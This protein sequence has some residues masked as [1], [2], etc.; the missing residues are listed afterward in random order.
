MYPYLVWIHPQVHFELGYHPRSLLPLVYKTQDLGSQGTNFFVKLRV[1]TH[2]FHCANTSE[3]KQIP[4]CCLPCFCQVQCGEYAFTRVQT[5]SF[6]CAG[7]KRERRRI[8]LFRRNCGCWSPWGANA[9]IGSPFFPKKW[10]VTINQEKARCYW[11]GT[12]AGKIYQKHIRP[13][14]EWCVLVGSCLH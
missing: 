8:G 7:W 6:G 5:N 14:R 10:F 12:K 13:G 4:S 3:R 9:T 1:G 2:T 11:V